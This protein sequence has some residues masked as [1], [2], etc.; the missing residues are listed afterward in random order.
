MDKL[1]EYYRATHDPGG[2]LQTKQ[3][4]K[5]GAVRYRR[6]VT[7]SMD[8]GGLFI[9]VRPPLGR[10]RKLLI[11]WDEIKTVREDRLYGRQ[12]VFMSIGAPEVGKITVYKELFELIRVYL[13]GNAPLGVKS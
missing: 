1:S 6:C 7:V 2:G 10:Q 5:L 13:K 12:A 11:P 4:V 9:W 3:T 8:V